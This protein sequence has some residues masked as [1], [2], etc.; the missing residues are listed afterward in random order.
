M[1]EVGGKKFLLSPSRLRRSLTRSLE[2]LLM[3]YLL[4]SH[5]PTLLSTPNPHSFE[6]QFFFL[7]ESAIRTLTCKRRRISGRQF[8]PLQ[9]KSNFSGATTGNASAEIVSVPRLSV[10]TKP[11]F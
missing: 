4:L 1:P 9:P 6:A 5:P 3:G 2:N 11:V 7:N 8:D 10:Y